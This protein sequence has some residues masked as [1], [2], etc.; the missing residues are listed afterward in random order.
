MQTDATLLANN[1]QHCWAQHVASVCLEPQ[2]CWHLLRKFETSQTFSPCKQTQHCSLKTLTTT[3][4]N[5]VT[6]CVRLHWPLIA[7]SVCW[8]WKTHPALSTILMILC[9]R[10]QKGLN[11]IV[12]KFPEKERAFCQQQ[13]VNFNHF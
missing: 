4:N 7:C 3:H 13:L 12:D 9:M 2:Q 6:C 10:D 5:V 1:T 8:S 11:N